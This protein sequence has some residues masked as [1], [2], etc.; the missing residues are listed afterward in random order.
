VAWQDF[1]RAF[2]K[3]LRKNPK[4]HENPTPEQAWGAVFET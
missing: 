2:L 4:K 3:K 1:L